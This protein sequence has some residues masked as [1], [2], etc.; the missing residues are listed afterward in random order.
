MYDVPEHEGEELSSDDEPYQQKES[1][2]V[3]NRTNIDGD[4]IFSWHR[5]NIPPI[6]IDASH[7]IHDE[8]V[9]DDLNTF[10]ND[11]SEEECTSIN[12]DSE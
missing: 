10:S 12:F 11:Q 3:S 7:L 9:N 5:D 8:V 6:S 4:D 2:N 1:L